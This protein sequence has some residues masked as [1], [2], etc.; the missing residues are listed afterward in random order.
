[1]RKAELWF[2]IAVLATCLWAPLKAPAEVWRFEPEPDRFEPAALLD[3]RALN[4]KVAGESGFVMATPAGDF[5]FAN[6]RPARFWCVNTIVGRERPWVKRPRWPGAEPDL[7]RHARF[8]AKRGV[9]MVRCHAHINPALQKDQP[10]PPMDQA[11]AEDI[12]WIWRVVA[13]MK[14]EGIYTTISPYWANSMSSDDAVWGTDWS[15][16][17]HG[18]LFFDEKLQAAYKAWMRALLAEPNPYTGIPL[19]REPA[20]AILQIQNEDSLLFWTFNGLKGGPRERL[21][22]KF[23]QWAAARYGSYAKAVEA[24]GGESLPGDRPPKADDHGVLDFRNLWDATTDGR[25]KIRPHGRMV[26]QIA[27]L[28]ETMR[29]FNGEIVRFLREDLGCKQ[30]VNAGNWRTADPALMDDAERWSYGAGEVIGVNRYFN[31]VHEGAQDGWAIVEGDQFTNATALGTEWLG[32]PVL[33]RQLAGRPIIIPESSWVFPNRWEAEGS[34][35]VSTYSSL[36]GVDG[37]Y[38][39]ATGVEGFQQP[40]SANGYMPSQGKWFCG[41]PMTLGQFPAAA[42]VYRS[43]MIAQAPPALVERRTTK[44]MWDGEAPL[45]VEREAFDPNRDEPGHAGGAAASSMDPRLFLRGP[46]EV[47]IGEGVP[48]H[49]LPESKRVKQVFHGAEEKTGG[50]KW[51]VVET[52]QAQGVAAFFEDRRV[53]QLA[54]VRIE[55]GNRYGAVW[56]VSMDGKPIRESTKLLVQVG[57]E[58]RPAGWKEEPATFESRRDQAKVDGFRVVSYGDAPWEVVRAE[59]QLKIRNTRA[60]KATS[61]DANG[62]PR[63]ELK[64]QRD[65]GGVS[66]AFPEDALYVVV[67]SAE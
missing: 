5:A 46:V 25:K 52:P 54:D 29:E 45:L 64:L 57:T 50:G 1:M 63:G 41:G 10:V 20:V 59:V 9:N 17:H 67:E 28:A 8:L 39:F 27:F 6:G 44:Q 7:A 35:L 18:L 43:G 2:A 55:S 11:N 19:A 21:G 51:C 60:T 26:D 61:L 56:V 23:A 49:D 65:A 37:F 33:L 47:R 66:F 58:A 14:R 4:E 16:Q 40:G 12:D 36:L 32:L 31:G 3:L 22:A 48:G 53:F 15:G 62:M 24:W 42:L 34:F 13:A 38:W 30:L